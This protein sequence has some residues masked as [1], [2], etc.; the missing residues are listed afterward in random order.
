MLLRTIGAGLLKLLRVLAYEWFVA[1]VY[2]VRELCQ[3]I[4]RWLERHRLPERERKTADGACV[5]IRR[6]VV[7][8][9]DP[10]IYSQ[11]ELLAQGLAVTW[12]NPDVQLFRL[13]A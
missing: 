4:G 2:L 5:P 9:P 7:S 3:L 10:L 8:H 6:D 1:L 12:D 11:T 13:G